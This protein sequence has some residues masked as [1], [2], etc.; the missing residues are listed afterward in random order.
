M[1]HFGIKEN[2]IILSVDETLLTIELI[3]QIR[4]YLNV[5]EK[6]LKTERI[7]RTTP[8]LNELNK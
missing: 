5:K 2:E 3:N 4:N 7:T 6:E 8:A 1:K